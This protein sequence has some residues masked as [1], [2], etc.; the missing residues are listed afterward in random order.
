MVLACGTICIEARHARCS[1]ARLPTECCTAFACRS[2]APAPTIPNI[3]KIT[4][5]E[6]RITIV[7]REPRIALKGKTSCFAKSPSKNRESTED[8]ACVHDACTKWFVSCLK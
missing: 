1:A 6:S 7:S 3:T 8:D 4:N 5:H 2:R